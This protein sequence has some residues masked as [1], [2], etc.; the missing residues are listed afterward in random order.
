MPMDFRNALMPR[1]GGGVGRGGVGGG[2]EVGGRVRGGG[3]EGRGR[4]GRG[5]RTGFLPAAQ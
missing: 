1:E 3:R 2:D 5:R 4:G